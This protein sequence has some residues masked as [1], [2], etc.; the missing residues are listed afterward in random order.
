MQPIA[1]LTSLNKSQTLLV[2]RI[3]EPLYQYLSA[4]A[5]MGMVK[6]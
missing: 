1:V 5:H 2:K 6:Y 3:V 4:E